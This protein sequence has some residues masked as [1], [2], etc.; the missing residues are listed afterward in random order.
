MGLPLIR[1]GDVR[2]RACADMRAII[3][4]GTKPVARDREIP[5]A[6]RLHASLLDD[7]LD[8]RFSQL[9]EPLLGEFHLKSHRCFGANSMDLGPI[10]RRSPSGGSA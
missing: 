10:G 4:A 7:A 8:P 5:S 2:E 6:T 9:I 3:I 1:L